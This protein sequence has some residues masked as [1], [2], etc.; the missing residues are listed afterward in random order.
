MKHLNN[1]A[2]IA[3]KIADSGRSTNKSTVSHVADGTGTLYEGKNVLASK[4]S[5]EFGDVAVLDKNDNVKKIIKRGT[6]DAATLP[7]N[8]VVF[9]VVFNRVGSKVM[10]AAKDGTSQQWAAPYQVKLVGFDFA[11]G[12]SFTATVNTTA[13][14]AI[15]YLTTDTLATTA[16]KLMAALEAAG[17]TAATG[18]SCTAGADYILVQQNWHTPNVTIFT[19]TDGSNKIA[20]TI[21]TGNY[22]TALAETVTPGIGI[23]AYGNITRVDG[24]YSYNAGANFPKFLLYYSVNG[25]ADTNQAV[26]ATSIIKEEN[27]TTELNPLLVAYYGTY[28]NY[29]AAKMARYPYSK[30]AILDI[31]G[32]SNTNKL[33]A[34]TYAKAD[35]TTGYA[36]PGAAYAKQYGITIAGLTTGLEAGNWY[37]GSVEEI[38]HLIKNITMGLSGI[39]TANCDYFNRSMSSVG[40]TLVRVTDYIWAS[41]EFSSNIAWRFTGFNGILYSNYKYS[42]YSVRPFIAF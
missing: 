41:S 13:T 18:W 27:F 4:L 14:A 40:G 34:V 22:Q 24:S 23:K 30:N 20:R 7:S 32:K 16:V 19:I 35:G 38:F 36:Y 5:A 8:L 37:Q 17:F 42:S 9:G 1:Y 3:A 11:T 21:L 15:E 31:N 10:V 33:A 26:G 28:S 29:I 2:T 12:G 39:T 25:T 6:Y